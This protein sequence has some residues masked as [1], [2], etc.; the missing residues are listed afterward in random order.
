MR[1]E[2]NSLSYFF[3]DVQ[4]QGYSKL[5]LSHNFQRR[6]GILAAM[7]VVYGLTGEVRDIKR[8][9][10]RER[11][12]ERKREKERERERSVRVNTKLCQLFE[13]RLS[14]QVI[15]Q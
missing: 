13:T 3:R 14:L 1:A 9:K 12:K 8:E 15:T 7:L 6:N 5:S 10:E 2:T 11:E 4:F